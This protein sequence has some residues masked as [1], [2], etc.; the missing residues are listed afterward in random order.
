[1]AEFLR[2]DQPVPTQAETML[3]RLA[4]KEDEKPQ[5]KVADEGSDSAPEPKVDEAKLDLLSEAKPDPVPPKESPAEKKDAGK[6][7]LDEVDD[8]LSGLLGGD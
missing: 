5:F 2:A 3:N 6:R 4:D 1:V 8:K 7:N